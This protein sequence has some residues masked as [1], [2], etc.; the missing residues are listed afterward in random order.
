MLMHTHHR[1]S[2]TRS[3]DSITR[4]F[5]G[6]ILI[7]FNLP[8][9]S[10]PTIVLNT[11][12]GPPVSNAAQTGFG[13]RVMSEA[14]RRIGYKLETS[15]LPAE[16]ALINANRGIDDGDLA[17]IGGLQ[18]QYPNLIQVPESY[19]T[20]DLVLYTKNYPAFTVTG[21]DSVASHSLAIISGWKILER[22]FAKLGN[23]VETIKTD[24]PE[25]SFSLLQN[26][27]VD[28][29]A[30]SNW[31]GMGYIKAHNITNVKLLKPPLARPKFYVYLHKK[32]EK[33]V[34]QLAA[35]IKS[36]KADGTLQ[37]LYDRLLKP[38]LQQDQQ[39]QN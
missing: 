37:T 39:Q 19:L 18:K 15:R 34:P 10:Q 26:D 32:H 31:S 25:Q 33:I 28:F 20:I 29:I 2:N 27:R 30:Y 38:Y 16:R 3:K 8:V 6:I 21:W 4:L 7:F 1:V 35:A 11:A 24:S 17:R 36:M 14:F 12:F 5:L 9:F 13:D 22:N 23:R